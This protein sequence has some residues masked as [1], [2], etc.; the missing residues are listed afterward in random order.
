[1][2]DLHT[3]AQA[4]D[5]C[6]PAIAGRDELAQRQRRNLFDVLNRG[7]NI[8]HSQGEF[9]NQA[10][11]QFSGCVFP[12]IGIRVAASPLSS[13][14]RLAGPIQSKS[15]L[16]RRLRDRIQFYLSL[17]RQLARDIRLAE[18]DATGLVE[19]ESMPCETFLR[20]ITRPSVLRGQLE[21]AS[22]IGAAYSKRYA[23]SRT[24]KNTDMSAGAVDREKAESK[25]FVVKPSNRD[26]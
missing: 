8:I 15:Q 5:A 11:Q 21:Y 9:R 7:P 3:V 16:N 25:P 2:N 22:L 4:I 23:D 13:A 24:S 20:K 18:R 10:S 1:M 14:G 17:R 12:P 19:C 26:H 6:L